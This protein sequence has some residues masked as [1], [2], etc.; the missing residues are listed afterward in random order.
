M[1][2]LNYISSLQ[3]QAL[4]ERSGLAPKSQS[5]KGDTE[6]EKSPVTLDTSRSTVQRLHLDPIE[7]IEYTIGGD[8][9]EGA[10]IISSSP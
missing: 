9:R 7:P 5:Q 1:K 8:P 4:A 2:D 6:C 10:I 3:A